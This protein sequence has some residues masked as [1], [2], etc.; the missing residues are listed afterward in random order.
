MKSIYF[1]N[2]L[3][4]AAMVLLSFMIIGLAL[5]FLGQNFIISSHRD[6]MKSNA[7]TVTRMLGSTDESELSDWETRI[8]LSG[9]AE[10]SGNDI[11]LTN[12][13]G[14]IVSCSDDPGKCPHIGQRIGASFM[15]TLQ[16]SGE[17]NMVS[18]LDGLYTSPRYVYAMPVGD[19]AGYVFVSTLRSNIMGAWDAFFWVFFAVTLAVLSLALVMS[20]VI[21]KKLAE[22][23]DEM[24]AAARR[25]AHGD[26]SVRVRE[27]KGTDE[28]AALTSSFNAMADSLERSEELRN[29]FIAN[30]SH[31]LKTPMTTIAG[32]ADGILDGTIPK[33]EEDKYLATIADETRRLSRLVRHMLSLSRMR[34]EGTDL[35]K[36]RDFDLNE[37]IIRTLLSFETRADDKHLKV[38][39]QLPEDHMTV[40]ADPDSITQVLY[41]LLDNAMKF[42]DEG[43]TITV[44]LWKQNG[45]A[46][47]SVKD[48]G[49][50]IPPDDLPLIFDRFHKSDRS[51][52]KDRDG[53]GLGLYLVK[54]ILDAHN[55]DIAV[56]SADGVT[57][58]VFTLTL[59]REK[60]RAEKAK[61]EKAARRRAAAEKN[62][63]DRPAAGGEPGT[64]S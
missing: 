30:V 51:R 2:F 28:L 32:F 54:S 17:L 45:K 15:Y 63:G 21:S 56:T 8:T 5:I 33:E 3:S 64:G 35:A 41:N 12:S 44:A 20:L 47:V 52:S 37:L 1:K 46:Y 39:L 22:P 60:P 16:N 53:V 10:V 29:E 25:F 6:D 50:T 43:G 42:A 59:A 31:E 57:E 61:A 11:L 48:R 23:L 55:E 36:R 13:D 7:I 19:D 58:F 27:D 38:D 9:A 4:T 62:G 34:S 24:T 14:L 40:T 26:F 49:D 18:D